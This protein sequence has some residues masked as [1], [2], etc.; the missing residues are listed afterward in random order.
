[1]GNYNFD[2]C[3]EVEFFTFQSSGITAVAI[4]NLPEGKLV[5]PTT[6][7]NCVIS[8]LYIHP[9]IR[10]YINIRV[11]NKNHNSKIIQLQFD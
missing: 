5:T 6:D 8:F 7:K 9:K 1:M 11:A 4:V 2:H 3:T 10:I